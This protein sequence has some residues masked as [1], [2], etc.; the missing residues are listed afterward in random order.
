M[1]FD[2]RG[3]EEAVPMKLE[4]WL[5]LDQLITIQQYSNYGWDLWFV[6][7]YKVDKPM[8]VL[9]NVVNDSTAILDRDGDV[10]HNHGY[11]FREDHDARI[12]D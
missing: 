7:R 6:R 11:T 1:N 10:I 5:S 8:V 3:K 2:D 9:K 12:S 4:R